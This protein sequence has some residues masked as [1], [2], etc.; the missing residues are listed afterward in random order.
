MLVRNVG[1]L[2]TTPMRSWTPARQRELPEGILDGI[3]TSLA[4]AYTI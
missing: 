3:M 4:R 2:M 1:H